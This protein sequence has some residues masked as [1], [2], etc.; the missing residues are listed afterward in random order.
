M[1]VW[2]IYNHQAAYAKKPDFNPLSGAGGLHGSARWHRAGQPVIYTAA[3]PSL[4]TL[5]II[6]H[7]GAELFGE[8]RLLELSLPAHSLEQVSEQAFIQLLRNAPPDDL[9]A[10]TR[11]YGTAW[12]RERRSLVLEVP[13]FV[14]PIERNY[15]LNPQHPAFA[16][17]EII[18]EELVTL[19]S[20]LMA[21]NIG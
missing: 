18:R 7:T 2:H 12:L 11:V 10:Q 5:E 6:V 16:K 9:E 8:R 20:R 14:M 1:R 3:S 17:V 13:S 15:L 19:D 21:Q 4:A